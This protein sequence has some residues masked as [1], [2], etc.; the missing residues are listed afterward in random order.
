MLISKIL[1][2]SF[3]VQGNRDLK[4]KPLNQLEETRWLTIS[5]K[6][7]ETIEWINNMRLSS[8]F[9]DVG[10]N[11][12]VYTAA[13]WVKGVERIVAFEP[14]QKSFESLSRLF[15]SNK[16]D[17][18]FLYNLGLALQ[19]RL[20]SLDGLVDISGAAEFSYS[21][22]FSRASSTALLSTFDAFLPL[23][24]SNRLYIKIDVDAEEVGVISTILSSLPSCLEVSCMVEVDLVNTES[25]FSM[26]DAHGYSIDIYYEEFCPHSL[27]RR[28][29]EVNNTAR[30]HV[31]SNY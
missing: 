20:V 28:L 5:T 14:F 1:P 12:G 6:E 4:L 29:K 30:N 2:P 17:S 10:A 7:P 8:T 22:N 11:I 27:Q 25:V 18:I 15:H 9:I 21:Q 23:I 24:H 19:N 26:F 13:A 3:S 16:V 31:F